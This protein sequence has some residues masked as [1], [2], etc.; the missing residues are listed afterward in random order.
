MPAHVPKIGAP[1]AGQF[2]DRLAQAPLIDQLAHSRALAA[3]NDQSRHALEIGGQ[4]HRN[5]LD[6][7]LAQDG[8]VLG[9]RRP[10]RRVHRS[11]RGFSR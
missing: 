9:I 6:A 2:E 8:N 5:R 4:A 11:A 3:G 10:A 7:E 1:L